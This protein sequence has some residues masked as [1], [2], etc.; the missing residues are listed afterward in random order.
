MTFKN[1]L[2]Y[3]LLFS[4][5]LQNRFLHLFVCCVHVPNF[6]T[7]CIIYKW[8]NRKI[9]C[10]K[11]LKYT[12]LFVPEFKET[13]IMF[14]LQRPLKYEILYISRSILF[15]PLFLDPFIF[16]ILYNFAFHAFFDRKCTQRRKI[17]QLFLW[18]F[19]YTIFFSN[20]LCLLYTVALV[21]I[22]DILRKLTWALG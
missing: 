19:L 15:L 5:F 21:C 2:P 9:V 18:T 1:H 17:F 22:S 3:Y 20:F 13:I 11:F 6:K 10:G 12:S 4:E 7:R 14:K 16:S 8:Q